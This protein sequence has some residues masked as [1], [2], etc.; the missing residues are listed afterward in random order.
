MVTSE[1][2]DEDSGDVIKKVRIIK[3]IDDEIDCKTI[4][5]ES[6][7][8]DL[9]SSESGLGSSQLQHAVMKRSSLR[10]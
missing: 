3:P 7:P 9:G 2:K 6:D 1:L 5:D 4:T 8:S 10:A